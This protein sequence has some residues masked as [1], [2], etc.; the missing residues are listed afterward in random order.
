MN[1]TSTDIVT[2]PEDALFV[3]APTK[4]QVITVLATALALTGVTAAAVY[5][6]KN[7]QVLENVDESV[8]VES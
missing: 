3:F 6:K 1:D 7:P 8:H 5:V 2:V 4:K